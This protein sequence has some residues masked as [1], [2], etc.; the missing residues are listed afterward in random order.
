MRCA[1]RWAEPTAVR[2]SLSAIPD[3]GLLPLRL[4]NGE[5]VV[6]IRRGDVVSVLEDECTHQAMP[7]SAGE[8][9]PDGTIECPWHGAR[10]DCATGACVRGPATDDVVT[11]DARLEGS[12]VVIGE[13]RR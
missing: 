1:K 12:E 6:L 11:Y 4:P 5:Q 2:V 9:L 13:R 10:F 7:L 3:E 8:L